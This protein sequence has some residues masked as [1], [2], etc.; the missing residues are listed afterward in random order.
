M[1]SLTDIGWLMIA[2]SVWMMVGHLV[3]G[4]WEDKK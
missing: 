3:D 1:D 2:V 4:Y